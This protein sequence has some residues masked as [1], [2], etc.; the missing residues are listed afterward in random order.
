MEEARPLLVRVASGPI[1]MRIGLNFFR[2]YPTL[3]VGED[4]PAWMVPLY[5]LVAQGTGCSEEEGRARI[6]RGE[7]SLTDVAY[8]DPRTA[9]VNGLGGRG[10]IVQRIEF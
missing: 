3:P 1:L 5:M 10:F 4:V 7:V 6:A 9:L 2:L 8:E